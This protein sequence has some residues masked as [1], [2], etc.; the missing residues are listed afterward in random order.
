MGRI[1]GTSDRKGLK[2]MYIR[3]RVLLLWVCMLMYLNMNIPLPSWLLNLNPELI[4]KIVYVL[5]VSS[6][7]VYVPIAHACTSH[8][9]A[10]CRRVCKHCA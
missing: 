5:P 8:V 1:V 6:A 10:A 4:T 2:S 9:R 7:S 3:I